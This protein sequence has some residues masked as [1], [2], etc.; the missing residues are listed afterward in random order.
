MYDDIDP[1]QR[2]FVERKFFYPED[3][4]ISYCN[5]FVLIWSY[6]FLKKIHVQ[7]RLGVFLTWF[8]SKGYLIGFF[9]LL[10]FNFKYTCM[11]AVIHAL[12]PQENVERQT[13]YLLANT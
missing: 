4:I 12:L 9:F 5:C 6:F 8:L 13:I 11:Y 2:N 7:G 1:Q 10:L 3:I